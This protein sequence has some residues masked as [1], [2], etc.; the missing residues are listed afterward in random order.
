MNITYISACM[1]TSGY[2][3]AAR[4]YIAALDS[5]GVGVRVKPVSFEK[6][7]SGS[8]YGKLGE[9]IKTLVD[10]GPEGKIQ[11][12]HLTP[13]N[14]PRLIRNDK[15]NIG[16]ATWETS[17]LPEQWVL[18]MNM[19]DELWVP[20]QY[21]AVTFKESGVKKPIYVIPHTFNRKHVFSKNV[22]EPVISVPEDTYTFYSIFQWTERKNPIDILKA[23]LTEFTDKDKVALVL[24]TYLIDPTDANQSGTIKDMIK[25]VKK[26]LYLSNLPKVMMINSLLSRDQIYSLHLHSDCYVSAHRCEG[27][28]IPIAEA[29]IAE[30]PVIV[31]PYGGPSDFVKDGETGFHIQYRETPVFG[32][33]W[34]TYRGDAVWADP[35][36]MNIRKHMRFV[37]ENKEKSQKIGKAGA[38]WINSNLSWESVGNLMKKRLEKINKEL[39]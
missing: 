24:K 38:D 10:K 16:Y 31:T 23:Y 4:N 37:Y 1:D 33:P 18:W 2:A 14:F 12:I 22:P 28:G 36:I 39:S 5:V 11:I 29:M 19:C 15:Y 13:E 34:P 32:M 6:F 35:D 21:N 25:A 30:K 8:S 27:F 20:S 26:R 17:K 7:K 3:E 9:K